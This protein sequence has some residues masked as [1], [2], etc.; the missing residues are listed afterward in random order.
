MLLNCWIPCHILQLQCICYDNKLYLFLD[1]SDKWIVGNMAAIMEVSETMKKNFLQFEPAP[2]RGEPE[3][4]FLL[5]AWSYGSIT[6]VWSCCSA[7]VAKSIGSEIFDTLTGCLTWDFS[8]LESI[9]QKDRLGRDNLH[10]R[11][12]LHFLH[13]F[14]LWWSVPLS[15]LMKFVFAGHTANPWLFLVEYHQCHSHEKH[16]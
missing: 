13:L 11:L 6:S 5:A 8:I 10:T 9:P 14:T 3:V 4:I 15:H 12:G 2:R 7:N 1:W 16:P